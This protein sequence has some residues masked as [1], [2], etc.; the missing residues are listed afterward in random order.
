[1]PYFQNL[2]KLYWR[3]NSVLSKSLRSSIRFHDIDSGLMR[4]YPVGDEFS[5]LDT[6]F[7]YRK[8]HLQDAA[9]RYFLEMLA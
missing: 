3:H 6:V 9:F 7:I 1:M 2:L 4:E 8:D 5:E